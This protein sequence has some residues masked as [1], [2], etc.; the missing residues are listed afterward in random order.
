[1]SG[2][3]PPAAR[4]WRRR[5]VRLGVRWGDGRV[6][7]D[8]VATTLGAGGLFVATP[9][10]PER[11]TRVHLRFRLRGTDPYIEAVARVVFAHLPEPSSERGSPGMGLE[12]IDPA[13]VSRLAQILEDLPEG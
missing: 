6:L 3:V 13:I 5:T 8:D 2:S 12:L 11:G 7:R 1:M 9:A 4:R 10:P